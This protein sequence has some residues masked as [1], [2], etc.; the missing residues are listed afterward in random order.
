MEPFDRTQGR[1]F[2]RL[3]RT[4]PHDE[5]SEAIESFDKLRTGCFERLERAAVL[6]R[7]HPCSEF[8]VPLLERF[9]TYI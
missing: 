3:E 1:R 2:E 6:L 7:F 4:D 9:R 8:G 5:Q